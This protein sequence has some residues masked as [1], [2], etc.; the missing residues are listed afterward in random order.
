MSKQTKMTIEQAEGIAKMVGAAMNFGDMCKMLKISETKFYAWLRTGKADF[1]A[2]YDTIE[3]Q[4]YRDVM[5][6]KDNLESRLEDVVVDAALNGQDPEERNIERIYDKDGK[7]I[8]TIDRLQRP[9]SPEAAK[10]WLARRSKLF[11]EKSDVSLEIHKVE[12]FVVQEKADVKDVE[13]NLASR[14]KESIEDV[15]NRLKNKEVAQ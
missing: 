8:K 1:R 15:V 3:A 9:A 10:W 7:L 5:I 12:D 14:Q 2:G 11:S 4:M 13:A 6:R